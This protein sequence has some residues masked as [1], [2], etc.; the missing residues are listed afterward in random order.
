MKNE[1]ILLWIVKVGLKFDLS[2]ERR[3]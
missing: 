3:I 1:T 2:F